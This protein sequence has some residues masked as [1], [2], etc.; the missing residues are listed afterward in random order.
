[1]VTDTPRDQHLM[2]QMRAFA[3]KFSG[4]SSGQLFGAVR[5]NEKTTED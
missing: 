1:M 3:K 4:I 2:H 5:G